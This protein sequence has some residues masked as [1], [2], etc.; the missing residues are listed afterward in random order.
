MN[1][2]VVGII[3]G[4]IVLIGVIWGG[5]VAYQHHTYAK[6]QLPG[7]VYKLN[8]N[9]GKVDKTNPLGLVMV[10]Y[11]AET[12]N[13]PIYLV[14]QKDGNHVAFEKTESAAKKDLSDTN[15][16]KKHSR[17][18][19]TKLTYLADKNSVRINGEAEG[20]KILKLT[21]SDLKFHQSKQ[22]VKGNF[23]LSSVVSSP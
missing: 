19:G 23:K 8:V 14:F 18:D 10:A 21:G 6:Y 16:L 20:E 9:Q 5:V 17:Y 4:L 22:K 7:H 15:H 12:D 13:L 11:A 3:L 2:K 1:K